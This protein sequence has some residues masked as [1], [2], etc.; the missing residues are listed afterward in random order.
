MNI[1]KLNEKLGK[2][3]FKEEIS[4]FFILTD[5]NYTINYG[6]KTFKK[7]VPK[8]DTLNY[9]LIDLGT[10]Q[11]ADI[12]ITAAEVNGLTLNT[13]DSTYIEY[14]PITGII[15]SKEPIALFSGDVQKATISFEMTLWTHPDRINTI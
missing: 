9:K 3:L 5:L 14:N 10:A 11:I 1:K 6:E 12:V 8:V 13:T 2:Y 7:V 4:D 15:R